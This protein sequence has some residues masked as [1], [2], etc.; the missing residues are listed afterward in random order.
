M[1]Q[2]RLEDGDWAVVRALYSEQI[3]QAEPGQQSVTIELSDEDEASSGA[4]EAVG[5]EEST[6]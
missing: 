2:R 1:E 6:A 3:E 5:S 4:N